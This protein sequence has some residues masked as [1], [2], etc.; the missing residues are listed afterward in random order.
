MMGGEGY[1]FCD[2]EYLFYRDG[3]WVD[4]DLCSLCSLNKTTTALSTSGYEC[5]GRCTNEWNNY[6]TKAPG[7]R[8]PTAAKTIPILITAPRVPAGTVQR[9]QL[10]KGRAPK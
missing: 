5:S 9:S 10:I 2:V 1:A 8:W 4:W 3:Q 6:E 7:A